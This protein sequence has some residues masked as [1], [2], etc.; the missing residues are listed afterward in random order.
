MPSSRAPANPGFPINGPFNHDPGAA[1]GAFENGARPPEL[2][3]ID[4]CLKPEG[5]AGR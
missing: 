4:V 2:A 1:H 5:F 3:F